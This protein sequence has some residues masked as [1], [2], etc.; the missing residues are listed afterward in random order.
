LPLEKPPLLL[1]EERRTEEALLLVLRPNP[2]DLICLEGFRV[3]K[4]FC[5][6]VGF[7]SGA[8]MAVAVLPRFGEVTLERNVLLELRVSEDVLVR[9]FILERYVLWGTGL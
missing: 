4:L 8:F 5:D 6:A 2:P 9:L 7:F 3:W 1:E